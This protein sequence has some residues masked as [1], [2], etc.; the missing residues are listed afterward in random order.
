[1]KLPDNPDFTVATVAGGITR[2]PP[3][4]VHKT[5]KRS[6]KSL[7]SQKHLSTSVYIGGGGEG[8]E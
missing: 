3:K 5:A 4:H 1:M 8:D 7:V 6:E 2:V